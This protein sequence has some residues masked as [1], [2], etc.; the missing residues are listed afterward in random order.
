MI[1]QIS[2]DM[3][4]SDL[5]LIDEDIQLLLLKEGMH[6]IGCISAVGET[7]EEAGLV[8]GLDPDVIVADINEY[9]A[10]KYKDDAE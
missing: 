3:Y 9:L 2:K 6:C 10:E 8:H 7:V 5:M 1:P 4:I